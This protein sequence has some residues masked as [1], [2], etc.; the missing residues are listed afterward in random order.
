[1]R[2]EISSSYAPFYNPNSNTG[3]PVATDT[4]SRP[5]KQTIF[6]DHAAASYVE[7]PVMPNP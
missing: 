2:V 7:L 5:A 4:E 1:V 6:H 3:N